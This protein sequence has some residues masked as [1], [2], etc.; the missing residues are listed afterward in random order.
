MVSFVILSAL[1]VLPAVTFYFLC[2]GHFEYTPDFKYEAGEISFVE[3]YRMHPNIMLQE[4]MIPVKQSVDESILHTWLLLPRMAEAIAVPVVVMAH[5]L[6]AQK[7]MGLLGY[8]E[9]FVEHNQCAVI[10]LDYRH[11]GGSTSKSD[12]ASDSNPSIRNWINPWMHVE[13]IHTV[14][15]A[16]QAGQF[17]EQIDPSRMILW[18]TSFAG[19]HMLTVASAYPPNTFLGV[20][21]QVPHLDGKAASLRALKSRGPVGFVRVMLLALVDLA[22]SKLF[23]GMFA[24]LYVK[25]VGTAQDTA[26]MILTEE[27]KYE[28]FKKHPTSYLGGWRNLAPARTLA[29]MSQYNP[30]T[31]VPNL[32]VP[33]LLIAATKDVLCP[34]EYVRNAQSLNPQHATLLE[35]DSSHFELYRGE[36]LDLITSRMVD[37][38]QS[39]TA[40]ASHKTESAAEET[41]TTAA[42]EA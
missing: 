5:G 8:A 23:P 40:P 32:K 41:A 15:A 20:I 4:V 31:A 25:I 7:D 39:Q 36:R 28:Y 35:I 16:V 29:M 19:G 27:E 1:L 12:D 24:P 38:I 21:S 18:G 13:D 6:G 10:V 42:A 2:R 9:K 26:Y 3:K 17:G 37:F 33:I 14:V 30:I 34:I 11:F 22:A